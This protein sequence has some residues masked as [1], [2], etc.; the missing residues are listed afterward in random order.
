M[1]ARRP[2]R[3]P[4]PASEP[5]AQDDIDLLE[6]FCREMEHEEIEFESWA[7]THSTLDLTL[8]VVINPESAKNGI[9]CEIRWCRT[10]TQADASSSKIT[11]VKLRENINLPGPINDGQILVLKGLGDEKDHRCGDLKVII[12]IK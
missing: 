1:A 2:T 5:S 3:V 12:R 11:R 9:N 6:Q 4:S 7:K 8:H 10:I